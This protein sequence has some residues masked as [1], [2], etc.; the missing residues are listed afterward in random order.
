MARLAAVSLSALTLVVGLSAP[1]RAAEPLPRTTPLHGDGL[2]PF[3]LVDPTPPVEVPAP[4]GSAYCDTHIID[5]NTDIWVDTE[6]DYLPHV[7]QCENGGANLEALKAQA[8]A[9]RSVL[10]YAMATNGHIC[11]GQGCQVYSCGATPNAK[12]HQAVEETA[13]Q[14]MMFNNTLTYG[15]YVAGDPNTSPPGCVGNDANAATEKYVTYNE[16]KTGV[17]VTQTTLGFIFDPN[18]NGYGQNR[19]CMGQWG[20]RCLENNNGYNHV[21]I[22]KFYY[23]ADIKIVTA[24][25]DCIETNDPPQGSLDAA[26]CTSA[27]GWAQDPDVPD[28]SIDVHVYLNGP[29]G[30][31]NAVGLQLVANEHRDD[32]CQQLGSCEHG[33]TV[34]IPRS[35]RDNAAHPVHAYGIDT[36]GGPNAQLSQSPQSFSCPPPPLPEGVRRHVSSPEVLSAWKFDLFWQLAK[37]DDAALAAIPEWDAIEP[38]PLLIR[39][40][41]GSPEVWLVDGPVRR[42][43][44]SPEVAAAWSFDL[45]TVVTLPVADVDALP[46]GTPVWDAPFLVQGTGPE[47]YTLDDRQC[48]EGSPDPACQD[49]GSTTGDPTGDPTDPTAGTSGSTGGTSSGTGSSGSDTGGSDTGGTEGSGTGDDSG[50]TAGAETALPPDFGATDYGD[51]CACATRDGRSGWGLWLLML[52]PFVCRGPRERKTALR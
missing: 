15:F 16:G 25:G 13:G 23:G 44:S 12:Q 38:A 37:L 49:G 52:V 4:I 27:R 40:D 33:F 26:D 3:P 6:T 21:D 43:V 46:L 2:S 45:N 20:A 8:I 51:G 7:I 9:A 24:S 50:T 47:V 39:S 30:D 48:Y 41:D 29:A 17:N 11:D 5:G 28:Q 42:H 10:Y 32:L 36:E 14:Y 18:D 22:L 35:L 19:G 34:E 31:P 1:V